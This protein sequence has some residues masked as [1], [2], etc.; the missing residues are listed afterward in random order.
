[1]LGVLVAI[2]ISA[3]AAKQSIDALEGSAS[4][5]ERVTNKYEVIKSTHSV[6]GIEC[7][8]KNSH[9]FSTLGKGVDILTKVAA[10]L[11]W[12]KEDQT[13][14]VRLLVDCTVAWSGYQSVL[15]PIYSPGSKHFE[16][17]QAEDLSKL[18]SALDTLSA[19]D[20]LS[21]FRFGIVVRRTRVV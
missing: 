21:L 3:L 10:T 17:L 15:S 8:V 19:E 1:M 16:C 6:C 9:D 11:G 14:V 5:L 12:S 18:Y 20:K 13:L 4:I 7:E 2:G